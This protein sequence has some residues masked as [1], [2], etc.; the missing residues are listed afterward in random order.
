[1]EIYCEE[2]RD[3]LNPK[4]KGTLKPREHP[5]LG[6]YVEGLS[7][8]VVTSYDDINQL[9]EEGNKARCVNH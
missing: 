3:L 9:M 7:K 1:M 6:P 4:I 5:I 2:V 8:L